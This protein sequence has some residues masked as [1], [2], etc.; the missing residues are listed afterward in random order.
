MNS[1]VLLGEGFTLM[2]LGMGFVLAFLFLLIF[3]IRGMSAA[4]NRFFPEPVPVPKAA[5]AAAPADDFARLKPVIAAAIH[6]HR[7]L[8]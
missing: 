4:V 8:N 5:P 6:H 7:R 2:F 3:A 1:S